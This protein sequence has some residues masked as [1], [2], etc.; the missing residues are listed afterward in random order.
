MQR[1]ASALLILFSACCFAPAQ[2]MPLSQVLIEGEGWQPARAV[3]IALWAHG[4]VRTTDGKEY[5]ILPAKGIVEM[6]DG[7][8]ER[9]VAEGIDVAGLVLWPDGGTLVVSDAQS[10]HLWAFRVEVD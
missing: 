2:D 10:K 3:D 9:R 5:S 4:P 1:G 6:R 7:V 8:T